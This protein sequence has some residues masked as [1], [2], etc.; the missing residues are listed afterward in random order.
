MSHQYVCGRN[1]NLGVPTQVT[2]LGKLKTPPPN[3][4]KTSLPLGQIVSYF[5][6]SSVTVI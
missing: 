1:S 2:L 3:R 5:L 4:S 6:T